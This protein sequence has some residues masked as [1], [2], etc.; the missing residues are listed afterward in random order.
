MFGP[1]SP[2]LSDRPARTRDAPVGSLCADTQQTHRLRSAWFQAA[3][4]CWGVRAEERS[5]SHA[6]TSTVPCPVQPSAIATRDHRE[7]K[8][9]A[10]VRVAATAVLWLGMALVAYWW[11][12][13][14][15]IGDRAG[16]QAGLASLGR[17]TGPGPPGLLL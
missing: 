11:A 14:G 4:R 1:A 17:R 15:G 7:A 2:R 5:M 6:M 10:A 3:G 8:A 16:W 13:G 12:A 9:D